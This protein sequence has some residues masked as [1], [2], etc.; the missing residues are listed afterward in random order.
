ML[1]IYVCGKF[2]YDKYV[3][4]LGEN[5]KTLYFSHKFS[6]FPNLKHSFKV[7]IFIKEYLLGMHLKIFRENFLSTGLK[8]YHAIWQLHLRAVLK[9]NKANLFLIHGAS[10]SA[11]KKIRKNG[12][13]IIGEV[14]N[15]HPALLKKQLSIEA[16]FCNQK[17]HFNDWSIEK[18]QSEVNFCDY[19]IA[20]SD[21]VAQS[22]SM[23][24]FPNSRIKVIPYG[25]ESNN[26]KRL[27]IK[28]KPTTNGPI[29]IICV[30]QI[31]LRKGQHRLIN[32][33]KN[34]DNYELTLVG[35]P[36]PTYLAS[37]YDMNVKF[38]HIHH[39]ENHEL[40][41]LIESHDLFVLPSI[42][43]GF[44]VVTVEAL[45]VGTPV[46][47]SKYAGSSEIVSKFG[48]GYVFDPTCAGD[49]ANKY[50]DFQKHGVPEI[51]GLIPNWNDYS[52]ELIKFVRDIVS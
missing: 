44:G 19:L 35:R 37:L 38:N 5:L 43:D 47:V 48:G 6:A 1:N 30:G 24:G 15:I 39:V 34:I 42:E 46:L 33:L 25:I 8:L 22:Y 7:N 20:P 13:V 17:F 36:D 10:L 32:E 27:V 18:I 50:E 26:E 4:L 21:S 31:C 40:L 2:H 52:K 11:I 12:G 3:H 9:P 28:N 29:K 49:F 16:A 41:R 51:N 14:V 45:S 23:M